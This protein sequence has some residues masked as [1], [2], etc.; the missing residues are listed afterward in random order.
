M[1][2]FFK[3]LHRFLDRISHFA[4]ILTRFV[5][6]VMMGGMVVDVLLNVVNRFLLKLSISWT[7]ELARILLVWISMMGAAVAVRTGAHIGV[8]FVIARCKRFLR[9]ILVFNWLLV[10]VFLSVVGYYGF[11]LCL[12]QS[13][14][15]S[16]VLRISMFWLYLSIPAGAF[17]MIIHIFPILGDPLAYFRE[18]NAATSMEADIH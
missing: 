7:E 5:L 16:P 15:L 18:E 13:G 17:L 10:M 8:T 2:R 6:A 14:Q 12:S 1:K 4:D 11:R 9:Y 3:K